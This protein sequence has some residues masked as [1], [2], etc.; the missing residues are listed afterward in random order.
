MRTFNWS[1]NLQQRARN[2]VRKC[3]LVGLNFIKNFKSAQFKY[4]EA[5]SSKFISQEVGKP[6]FLKNVGVISETYE[7]SGDYGIFLN[8]CRVSAWKF[9]VEKYSINT[10]S[11]LIDFGCSNGSWAKNWNTLGF[12]NVVGIDVNPKVIHE[13]RDRLGK[14][15]QGD[16]DYVVK[17]FSSIETIAVNGVFVHILEEEQVVKTLANLASSLSGSGYCIFSVLNSSYYI[18]PEGF[19][20]W[21]GPNS[22]TR[23]LD[24]HRTCCAKA[25]LEIIGMVGS[26]INPWFTESTV[27]IANDANLKS[28]LRTYSSMEVF[29]NVLREHEQ[30]DPFSEVYFITRKIK[31]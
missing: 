29:A 14:A 11:R 18:T 31:A 30:L 3:G 28:D 12:S 19:K 27:Y 2:I 25:G 20:P 22:C 26:F 6:S 21:T 10:N 4:K 9:I 8:N 15:E 23:T 16:A 24:Y 1:T 17:N 13:A 7:G 5:E